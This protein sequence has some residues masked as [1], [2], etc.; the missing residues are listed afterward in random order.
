MSTERCDLEVLRDNRYRARLLCWNLRAGSKSPHRISILL[1]DE[2]L[3]LPTCTQ[4]LAPIEAPCTPG[5]FTNARLLRIRGWH[6]P[7]NGTQV[8]TGPPCGIHTRGAGSDAVMSR[9][10]NMP[11]ALRVRR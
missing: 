6:A 10:N 3:T 2:F 5:A 1:Y 9:R 11:A 8:A 7:Y 4:A